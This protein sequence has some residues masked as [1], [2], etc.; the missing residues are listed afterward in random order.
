MTTPS[1]SAPAAGPRAVAPPGRGVLTVATLTVAC[2]V[3]FALA[4]V[5]LMTTGFLASSGYT[6]LADAYPTGFAVMNVGVLL[7]KLL[8][9]AVALLSVVRAPRWP[10]PA[11]VGVSVW[12]AFATLGVY[13]LGSTAQGLG[14]AAGLA[15]DDGLGVRSVAY[16]LFFLVFAGGFGVLAVSYHRR[17]GL[18][19]RHVALGALGGPLVLGLVTV[20][21]AVLTAV[22]LVPSG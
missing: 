10:G 5:D 12:A 17:A 19:A 1:S 14:M 18:G 8:G 21:I 6:R 11:L 15:D 4:N 2:C 22:G 16:L 20:A 13:S 7:L 9:A 3:G